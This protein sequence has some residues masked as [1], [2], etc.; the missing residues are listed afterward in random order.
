MM[1][2]GLIF[3]CKLF[4]TGF[5]GLRHLEARQG[6]VLRCRG[7]GSSLAWKPVFPLPPESALCFAA[8]V[9]VTLSIGLMGS[10]HCPAWSP[11]G[12][13]ACLGKLC[14][15]STVPTLLPS[16]RV[17]SAAAGSMLNPMFVQSLYT[18]SHQ[19]PEELCSP[20]HA[21]PGLSTYSCTLAHLPFAD[22]WS[23][24]SLLLWLY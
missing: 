13:A 21:M 1:S 17:S 5:C 7:V 15:Q 4:P 3:A 9:C 10:C 23:T 14:L 11:A 19:T 24:G 22:F 18:A 12:R 20:H 8:R 6:V 16:T 2:I